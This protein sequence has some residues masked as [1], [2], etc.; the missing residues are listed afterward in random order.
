MAGKPGTHPG[1]RQQTRAPERTEQNHR[2]KERVAAELGRP[3]SVRE[4]ERYR[5]AQR[6]AGLWDDAAP[7]PNGTGVPRGT[8]E[9]RGSAVTRLVEDRRLDFLTDDDLSPVGRLLGRVLDGKVTRGYLTLTIQT[10][11]DYAHTV[12]DAVLLSG[13][14]LLVT[15]HQVHVR[16]PEPGASPPSPEED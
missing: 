5:R 10:A 6:Q 3:V 1:G 14:L 8:L 9:N 16:R 12:A 4:A 7:A 2:L 11:P 15:L 13:H